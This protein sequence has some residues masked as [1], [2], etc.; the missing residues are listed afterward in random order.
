MDKARLK[1]IP[2]FAN[3]DDHDLQV[4][5][6]FAS[7]SSVSEGEILVREG[8]FSYDLI[9]IAEGTAEVRRGP[10]VVAELGPGDF[11]GEIGVMK[12][13]LRNATVAARTGMRIITLS[14]WELKRM[15]NMPGVME[16]IEKAVTAR[17]MG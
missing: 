14:T 12:N 15:R 1:A 6:T 11:F 13:A 7:E 2:L 17:S 10:D 3:L 5:A 4:I 8:D 9:A 16:E